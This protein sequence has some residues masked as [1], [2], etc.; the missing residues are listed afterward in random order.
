[1]E[2]RSVSSMDNEHTQGD[3]FTVVPPRR[4]SIP[5]ANHVTTPHT[6]LESSNPYAPLADVEQPAQ[7]FLSKT[8]RDI[9]KKVQSL[10]LDEKVAT[11]TSETIINDVKSKN[12]YIHADRSPDDDGIKRSFEHILNDATLNIAIALKHL[13]TARAHDEVNES[14]TDKPSKKIAPWIIHYKA[15]LSALMYDSARALNSLVFLG[16]PSK[17]VYNFET[18]KIIHIQDQKIEADEATIDP[19]NFF[20]NKKRCIDSEKRAIE[21]L[22]SNSQIILMVC[23][24]FKDP[25]GGQK[26][27]N[28]IN[29]Y[30]Q[31]F[32]W[33]QDQQELENREQL[34]KVAA[35]QALSPEQKLEKN[36]QLAARLGA[37]L[38]AANINVLL[39]PFDGVDVAQ[40]DIEEVDKQKQSEWKEQNELWLKENYPGIQI[41]RFADFKKTI[42]YQLA[43][44]LMST[45][46]ISRRDRIINKKLIET[47]I[48]TYL[49]KLADGDSII[50]DPIDKT[51]KAKVKVKGRISEVNADEVK[52]EI[53]RARP[54][55]LNSMAIQRTK[56]MAIPSPSPTTSPDT[57][58]ST[59]SNTPVLSSSAGLIKGSSSPGGNGL[60]LSRTPPTALNLGKK[61]QK[62]QKDTNENAY[63]NG[64]ISPSTPSAPQG[65]TSPSSSGSGRDPVL[66]NMFSFINS[67][68]EVDMKRMTHFA[69]SYV[70]KKKQLSPEKDKP[71]SQTRLAED[72]SANRRLKLGGSSSE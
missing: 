48:S 35:D 9:W 64:D 21:R 33:L 55:H 4:N 10:P 20:E 27:K 58:A 47:D 59:S 28:T 63:S 34:E 51:P 12:R 56:N 61:D 25:L 32:K 62:D 1:M 7:N 45:Y 46:L 43:Q 40:E 15:A 66:Y 41:T 71:T 30:L 2:G 23:C 53:D 19:E 60:F 8:M 72:S 69:T 18:D 22:D 38:T 39:L 3:G 31:L 70:Q 5:S 6:P 67:A 42:Y 57:S 54:M 44:F 49:S 14:K 65:V 16:D 37:E 52:E 26:L 11:Q 17:K 68:G 13:D 50:F 24:G 36:K 29:N